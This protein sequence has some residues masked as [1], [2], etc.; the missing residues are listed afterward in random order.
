[1]AAKTT[2]TRKKTPARRTTVT[3]RATARS[4]SLAGRIARKGG[5]WAA[6]AYARRRAN[7]R[8]YRDAAT[9]RLVHAGCEKCGG[10]GRITKRG[11]DGEFAGSKTCTA[12]PKKIKASRVK[13][14]IESRYGQ[15]KRSGLH[16][17]SCPCG[18]KT[19]PHCRTPADATTEL[20]AHEKKRHDGDS[21]GG[22][23]Y[24]QIPANGLTAPTTKTAVLAAA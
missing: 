8:A 9:M 16:G 22:A 24:L 18:W 21:L 19:K 11:K 10:S 20:R 2:S 1:M 12:K 23:W 13:V 7:R 4:K 17:S 5:T 14:A 3:K 15:D 6:R